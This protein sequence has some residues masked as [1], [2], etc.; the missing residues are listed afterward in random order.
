MLNINEAYMHDQ[1]MDVF[2]VIQSCEVVE[3]GVFVRAAWWNLGAT[4]QNPWSIG[5]LDEFFISDANLKKWKSIDVN[6]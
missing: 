4:G 2:I 3:G 5:H 1:C 6:I